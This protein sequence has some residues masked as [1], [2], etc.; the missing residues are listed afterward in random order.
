MP[1]IIGNQSRFVDLSLYF[2]VIPDKKSACFSLGGALK[3]WDFWTVLKCEIECC[4]DDN[5]NT[6]TPTLT[7]SAITVFTP[8]GNTKYPP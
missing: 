7:Q 8:D 5:C 4:T 3:A 2:I 6:Q 1:L